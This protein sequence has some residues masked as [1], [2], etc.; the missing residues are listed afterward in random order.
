MLHEMNLFNSATASSLHSWTTRRQ[1]FMELMGIMFR[2]PWLLTAAILPNMITPALEP[3]QAWIAKNV[4]NG[5][6]EGEA[7]FPIED[8]LPYVWIAV[9]VFVGLGLLHLA[10]KISNRMLDD[11]LFIELQRTWFDRRGQRCPGEQVA[12]A[13]N[14]CESARKVLD[15][16]Q[17]ELWTVVIGLPAVVIWQLSLAPEWLPALLLAASPP[18]IA[19]LFFGGLIQNASLRVLRFVAAVGSAVASGDR[20]DLYVQQENFYRNR[21]LFEVWKQC[22]ETTAEFARWLG[23]VMVL[24]IS[25]SGVWAVV[26]PEVTAGEVG[27][28]LV[29]VSLLAKPLAEVAKVHNKIREGWP[30]VCRTL[31]PMDAPSPTVTRT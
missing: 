29:N 5:I 21:V 16:F 9:A 24:L 31:R 27:L 22:S 18:F 30:G 6:T 28:F 14:D 19:A 26:P 8:L 20:A 1:L 17:K 25:V 13:M 15:L 12:R 10:E 4:L 3:A 2:H 7:T 23:I 11:R